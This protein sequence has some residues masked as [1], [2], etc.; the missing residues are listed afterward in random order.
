M[1]KAFVD[2]GVVVITDVFE[3][4]ICDRYVDKIV[5][6]FEKLGTGIDHKKIKETWTDHN[7]PPQTRAGLF[8]SIVSNI[9]EVWEIR[10]HANVRKIFETIYSHLRERTIKD[11]IVSNDGINGLPPYHK[12]NS[13]SDWP[14]VDQTIRGNPLLCVQGQAV[15]T[16]T[17][18]ALRASL[19]SHQIH[20]HL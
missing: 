17:S 1:T 20:D 9:P 14:H 6:C 19:K 10:S 16:N 12:S 4:N 13:N 7:L 18:S 3:S 2:D 8:Q 15:L 11:F 5:N